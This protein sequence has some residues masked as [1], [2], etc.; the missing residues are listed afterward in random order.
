MRDPFCI[1]FHNMAPPFGADDLVRDN[2]IGLERLLGG[3][4]PCKVTIEKSHRR[5]SRGN[6]FRI[7][8]ELTVLD[9]RIVVHRDPPDGG[10]HEGLQTAIT[11]A[12]NVAQQ[13]LEERGLGRIREIKVSSVAGNQG[14]SSVSVT[15][16]VG[17][18]PG[19]AAAI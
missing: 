9:Q 2:A 1:A 16:Q 5:G 7:A 17:A 11:D 4:I 3:A 14:H 8:I 13:R 10:T 12:F 15:E 19:G 18:E 6:L